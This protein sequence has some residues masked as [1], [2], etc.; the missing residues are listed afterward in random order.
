MIGCALALA[1]AGAAAHDTWFEAM[2]AAAAGGVAFALGTGNRFP[3]QEFAIGIEQLV[4]SGCRDAAGALV[5]L[6]HLQDQPNALWL[7]AGVRADAAPSCWAQVQPFEVE[8]APHIVELYLKEIQA[9][10]AVREAW[11]AMRGRGVSWKE[12]YTKHARIET[13]RPGV[14]ISTRP[15]PM[16]MDVLLESDGPVGVDRPLVLQVLRDGRPLADF[17]VELQS[18]ASG[19]GI[20]RRTDAHGRVTFS[21]P[22]AGRWLLRGTDLRLSQSQ[23]DY[24]ESRFVTLAFDVPAAAASLRQ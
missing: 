3:L 13:L 9:P 8:I 12:R 10:A 17:A 5:P 14:A 21:P 2:P 7:R 1:A 20:W 4:T 11:A 22:L 24:W 18:H 23:P 15:V 16:A 6:R 19:L